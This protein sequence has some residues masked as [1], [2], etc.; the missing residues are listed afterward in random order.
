VEPI[1]GERYKVVIVETLGIF[2]VSFTTEARIEEV[3]EGVSI[4]AAVTGNDRKLGSGFKQT[5]EAVFAQPGPLETQ[6]GLTTEVQ[7]MGKIAG[8]GYGILKRKADE[9]LVKFGNA[10][11]AELEGP[12]DIP[13]GGHRTA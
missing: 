13:L 9:A 11:R 7:F 4:K 6:V 2:R 5:L 10:V 12:A 3:N 8:L 1:D